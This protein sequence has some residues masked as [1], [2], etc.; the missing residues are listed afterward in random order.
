MKKFYVILILIFVIGFSVFVY[1]R[2]YTIGDNEL[3]LKN[4]I[5]QF[6]NRGSSV[7]NSISIK[8]SIRHR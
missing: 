4:R 6:I 5:E 3:Q 8:K 2:S 1:T 7:T